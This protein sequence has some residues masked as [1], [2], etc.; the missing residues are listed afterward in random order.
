M[1]IKIIVQHKLTD[2]LQ[3]SISIIE[4]RVKIPILD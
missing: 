2:I 1:F 3:V 4:L